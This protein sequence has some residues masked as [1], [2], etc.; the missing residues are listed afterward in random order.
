MVVQEDERKF[1]LVGRAFVCLL[2]WENPREGS[3]RESGYRNEGK[4]RCEASSRPGTTTEVEG[5]E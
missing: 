5:R 4:R 3:G 2:R 1:R